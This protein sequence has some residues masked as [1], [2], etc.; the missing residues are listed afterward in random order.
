MNIADVF[1]IPSMLLTQEVRQRMKAN[2]I[3]INMESFLSD[4]EDDNMGDPI[5]SDVEAED[6]ECGKNGDDECRIY[7]QNV[8]FLDINVTN[9]T[10]EG[11]RE[12]DGILW[13]KIL[14]SIN[15]WKR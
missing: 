4:V 7:G 10:T 8:P 5:G 9:T 3:E 2:A 12:V 14:T 1:I 13:E 11:K 6:N 15:Q